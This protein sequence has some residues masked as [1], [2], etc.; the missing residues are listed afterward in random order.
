MKSEIDMDHMKKLLNIKIALITSALKSLGRIQKVFGLVDRETLYFEGGLGSQIISAMSFWDLLEISNIKAGRPKCDLTYY[1]IDQNKTLTNGLSVWR[2]RLDRYGISKE[3][4]ENEGYVKR[5]IPLKARVDHG[6][7]FTDHSRVNWAAK[8]EKYSSRFPIDYD[9]A[10]DFLENFMD[11]NLD[12]EFAAIHIRRG[13][14]LSVATHLVDDATYL[15]LLRKVDAIL[16][17]PVIFFSDSPLPQK[18]RDDA[19]A[20]LKGK[21]VYFHD[22]KTEDECLIHDVMR[23]SKLLI[24]SNSTFSFTA[25]L[26]ASVDCLVFS[27]MRFYGGKYGDNLGKSFRDAADFFLFA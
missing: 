3:Q 5:K 16:P 20:I 4:F 12:S 9:A 11:L 27:P 15:A 26:L 6:A 21:L 8:R 1:E 24:T 14:Y 18:F 13:D 23:M 2:W 7:E 22:D 10:R 25:G 19:V 17:T